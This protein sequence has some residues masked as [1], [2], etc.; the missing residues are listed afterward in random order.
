MTHMTIG[1]AWTVLG[2]D[3]K[4]VITR[5]IQ[6]PKS[7]RVEAAHKEL[8]E[9]KKTA[10]QLLALHHPDRGGDPEKFKRVNEAIQSIEAHTAEFSKKMIEVLISDEDRASKSPFIKFNP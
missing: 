10:K 7:K 5:L 6:T 2:F 3:F 9:A 8:E 1:I 4:D